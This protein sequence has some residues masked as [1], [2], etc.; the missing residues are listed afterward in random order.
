MSLFQRGQ[1][2][3]DDTDVS[4]HVLLWGY[5]EYETGVA[6]GEKRRGVPSGKIAERI[7]TQMVFSENIFGE[8]EFSAITMTVE[9]GISA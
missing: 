4:F 5:Q 1:F 9:T 7:I 2:R 3:Q 6:R 8:E